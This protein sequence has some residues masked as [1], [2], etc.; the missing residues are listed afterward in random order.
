MADKTIQIK[1]LDEIR[2]SFANADSLVARHGRSLL[3]D[4]SIYGVK[5]MQKNILS[6]GAVD[7]NELI[8]GIHYEI[9]NNFNGISST[10]RP[11]DTADKYAWFMEAGTR[12]HWAPRD[13]LQGWADR[14]GIP[15]FLV[16]KAI[17]EKGTKPRKYAERTFKEVKIKTDKEVPRFIDLVIKDL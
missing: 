6:V 1:G 12:P 9:K 2:A 4:V 13:A 5:Q 8:Q 7:T 11:N 14:H 17:A 3:R 10:I 15:V 16:Q